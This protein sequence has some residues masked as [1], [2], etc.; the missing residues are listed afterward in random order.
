M[1]PVP[2]ILTK[3]NMAET[4]L[5]HFLGPRLKKLATSTSH[6][7]NTCLWNQLPCY[8]EAQEAP[9]RS[10]GEEEPRLGSQPIE[11]TGSDPLAPETNSSQCPTD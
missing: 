5:C 11:S 4:M 1:S 10:P 3:G 7:S 8:E 2:W 6:L 9:W